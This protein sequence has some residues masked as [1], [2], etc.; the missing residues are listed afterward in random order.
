MRRSEE[1]FAELKRGVELDPL[2]PTTN[3][4]LAGTFYLV[5]QYDQAIEQERKTLD[6]DPN[7]VM[8]HFYLGLTYVHKQAIAEL[9]KAV[10]ISPGNTLLL[11]G[12][13]YAF[14]VSDRRAE[15]AKDA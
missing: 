6:L 9:E 8:A 10:A 3:Q 2:S 4:F 7:F 5:R 12:L 11:A 15:D 13:G 1:G 14:A